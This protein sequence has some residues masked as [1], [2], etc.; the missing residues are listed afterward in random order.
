MKRIA[1]LITIALLVAL[2]AGFTAP[3]SGY[4]LFQQ[5]LVKERAEG[6]LQ[7]AIQLCQ[8]IVRDFSNDRPLAAKALLQMGE[9]YEKLGKDEARKAYERV[10]RDYPDQKEAV[11]E[12][13]ARLGRYES[14]QQAGT[15]SS[16]KVWTPPPSSTIYGTVSHDGRYL[17]YT[18]WAVPNGNGELFVHDTATGADRRITHDVEKFGQGYA[19]DVTFS[20]GDTQLAY[21]W[22][23]K[24]HHEL[25]II[26][27]QA[28]DNSRP[29][30]LF[31]DPEV[32]KISPGDW[33]ADGKWLA[34]WLERKNKTVQIGLVGVRDGSL[35]ILKSF[36]P[37]A[38]SKLFFSPDS[39]Y[40]AYDLQIT[41]M[42]YRRDVF[43]LTVDGS[44]EIPAVV[45]PAND[46]LMGWSP[47]GRHL[48]FTSDRTGSPGLWALAFVDGK[49]QG[50][51]EQI[52]ADVTG[53]SMGLTSSGALYLHVHHSN[54]MITR[55]DIQAAEF[56]FERGQFLSTPVV[57]VEA[58]VG[59]NNFPAWSPD[60]KSLAFL[61]QR[62]ALFSGGLGGIVIAILSRDSGQVRELPPQVKAFL[63]G[64]QWSPDGLSL[65]ISGS[66][67][68]GRQGIF[69]IDATTGEA[70]AI[71]LSSP[72]PA[73]GGMYLFPVWAPDGKRIYYHHITPQG[74]FLAI[75]EH[76]L[77][78]GNEKEVIRRSGSTIP[79]DLALS[80]DG[81]YW[82]A[83]DGDWFGGPPVT[84]GTTR[85]WNVLL[86]P[87]SGGEPK[88]LM[89]GESQGA[90]VLMWAPDS[91]SFF[92]YSIKDK[93]TGDREVWR[94]WVDGAQP[95]KLD[96]NVDFLGPQPASD[97]RLHPHPDGK[98][99]A[100]AATEP[101]KPDEV[102]VMENFLPP[103]E[104]SK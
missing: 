72:G 78:S 102:W 94:V 41:D 90:G 40:L 1:A 97:Q 16:R 103:A 24:E 96:L 30:V 71:A 75:V 29:R 99:V 33:S 80:S 65:A 46:V 48:L 81:R 53:D 47:D 42:G 91:R 12:A 50:A 28:P 26:G 95:Q 104:K 74:A 4:D 61:S 76:E 101:A 88:E 64:L 98:R 3:Q 21:A 44:R 59:A 38:Y 58:F 2:G 32:P 92:I 31:S 6:N 18:L 87:A 39:K 93:S 8:R 15:I 56:D 79:M 5:A 37:P 51:P 23:N 17:P 66:D 35:R 100:F 84:P 69:R 10:L 14:A 63:P 67:A 77:S 36:D 73:G 22:F 83:L 82:A 27:L 9:C 55:S 70:T 52:K 13:R 62:G 19:W 7:E 86:I 11:S 60:G 49:P 43:V 57:A 89:R 25:R 45:H 20:P 85:K 68:K 34:V 54:F